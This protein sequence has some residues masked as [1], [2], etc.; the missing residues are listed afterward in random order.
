MLCLKSILFLL[1]LVIFNSKAINPKF[2]KKII[3]YQNQKIKK[4][5]NSNKLKANPD[6]PNSAE[7]IE[8]IK[9]GK[10]DDAKALLVKATKDSEIE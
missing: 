8:L 10:D 5:I 6:D 4:Q 2:L 7:F 1:K 3:R 9:D